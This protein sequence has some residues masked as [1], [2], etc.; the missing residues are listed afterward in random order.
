MNG[1]SAKQTSDFEALAGSWMVARLV[2][3]KLVVAGAG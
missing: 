2:S 3:W 1:V